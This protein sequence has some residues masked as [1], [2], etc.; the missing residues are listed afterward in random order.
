MLVSPEM[1]TGKGGCSVRDSPKVSIARRLQKMNKLMLR[2][3]ENVNIVK[4]RELHIFNH[5]QGRVRYYYERRILESQH[6]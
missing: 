4:K 1:T 5:L 2:R 3:L 6:E